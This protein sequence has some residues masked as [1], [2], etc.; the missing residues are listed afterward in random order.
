MRWIA[1]WMYA[2]L[3]GQSLRGAMARNKEASDLLG[4]TIRQI[5]E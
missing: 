5:L 2:V 4:R 1:H 3:M